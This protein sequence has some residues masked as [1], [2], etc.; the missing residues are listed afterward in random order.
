MNTT[1]IEQQLN[2]WQHRWTYFWFIE[3]LNR[4]KES[5]IRPLR[6]LPHWDW[7]YLGSTINGQPLTI[8]HININY[9]GAP[10]TCIAW[11]VNASWS[12]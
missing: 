1:S 4:T 9:P 7:H 12:K 8:G 11:C 2:L 5:N 3:P 6:I 10:C